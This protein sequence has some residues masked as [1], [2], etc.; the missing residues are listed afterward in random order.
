MIKKIKIKIERPVK[1]TFKS[2]GNQLAH[3][4]IIKKVV[5]VVI[6]CRLPIIIELIVFE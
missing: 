3:I 1:I 4:P 2:K 5:K 6:K